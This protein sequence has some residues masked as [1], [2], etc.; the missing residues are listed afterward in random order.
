MKPTYWMKD[1]QVL[2]NIGHVL[3]GYAVLITAAM[4]TRDL[5]LLSEVEAAMA[6]YVLFKEYWFDLRYE[7]GET[8]A[9]STEDAAGYLIGSVSAVLLLFV[10]HYVLPT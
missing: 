9:S 3:G 1:P 6:V 4:F 7:D 5:R 2:A 10:R 8:F